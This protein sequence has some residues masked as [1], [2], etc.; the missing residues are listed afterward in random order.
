MPELSILN[1]KAEQQAKYLEELNAASPEERAKIALRNSGFAS[2]IHNA[3][4]NG[5]PIIVNFG[6][7]N[8]Q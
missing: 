1:R 3:R 6:A 2:A 5:I 7:R 4:E 8:P